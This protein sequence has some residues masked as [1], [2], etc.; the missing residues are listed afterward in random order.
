[1]P[2][3]K[4]RTRQDQPGI[5]LP[6]F[7]S[8]N[9]KMAH[10]AW[11]ALW[12]LDGLFLWR[13]ELFSK[14]IIQPQSDHCPLRS[15][16]IFNVFYVLLMALIWQLP[17]DTSCCSWASALVSLMSQVP[18]D[19]WCRFSVVSQVGKLKTWEPIHCWVHFCVQESLVREI[20][21]AS[22]AGQGWHQAEL[23][24][25]KRHCLEAR[26]H[27]ELDVTFIWRFNAFNICQS[28]GT[29]SSWTHAGLLKEL[30]C[31]WLLL[32]FQYLKY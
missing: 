30:H 6:C 1:M 5:S 16:W 24:I 10:R 12:F 20:L 18:V 32:L 22:A 23:L 4:P 7:L 27:S 29:D 31:P 25:L 11:A 21:T 9:G 19:G 17:E 3:K 15:L 14:M 13:G 26:N 28:L 8:E 2:R